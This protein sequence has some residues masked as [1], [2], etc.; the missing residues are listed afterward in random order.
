MNQPDM[1][2]EKFVE[3]LRRKINNEP[4]Q[5]LSEF[6]I[7]T[8]AILTFSEFKPELT[9]PKWLDSAITEATQ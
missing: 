9:N 3:S 4:M 2:R 1:T 5:G 6:R 8:L 7:Q